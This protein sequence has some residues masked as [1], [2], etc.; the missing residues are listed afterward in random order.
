MGRISPIYKQCYKLVI[1]PMIFIELM[2]SSWILCR[3]L[4]EIVRLVTASPRT[5]V[6]SSLSKNTSTYVCVLL[7]TNLFVL[8][9]VSGVVISWAWVHLKLSSVLFLL[10]N[11]IFLWELWRSVI[12]TLQHSQ[13][14]LTSNGQTF[15]LF[16]N[17]FSMA[18]AWLTHGPLYYM[19]FRYKSTTYYCAV[20]LIPPLLI[21]RSWEVFTVSAEPTAFILHI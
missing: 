1:K 13:S 2:G 12:N 15:A 9:G 18:D 4:A 21:Q 20:F 11:W 17:I 14:P 5:A 19:I 16:T 6:V 7:T 8:K 3:S 10:N